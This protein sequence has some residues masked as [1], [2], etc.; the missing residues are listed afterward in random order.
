[1]GYDGHVQAVGFAGLQVQELEDLM[2]AVKAKYPEVLSHVVIAVGM[3]PN[4]ELGQRPLAGAQ[5]LAEKI[6][7]VIQVCENIKM[8][9]NEYG[10]SF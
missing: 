8:T 2:Q 7:E 5:V 9:L 1:M 6:D 10:S 3:A 4:T